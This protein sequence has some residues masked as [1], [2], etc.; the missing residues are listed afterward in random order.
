MN[1]RGE[2]LVVDDDAESRRALSTTLQGAGVTNVALGSAEARAWLTDNAPRAIVLDLVANRAAGYDLLATVRADPVRGDTPVLVLVARDASEELSQALAAGADDYVHKPCAPA[3]LLL[4]VRAQLRMLEYREHLGR[5]ERDQRAET[6]RRMK[7]FQRYVDF[8][9]SSAD[10][11]IVIDRSG[12]LLFANPRAC[13]I[14]GLTGEE[15]LGRRFP[16]LVA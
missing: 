3:E 1:L 16:D 6:E 8:F 13:A 15:L 4:R 9:E 12:A 14:L 10:G 7:L 11:M 2:F 5:R